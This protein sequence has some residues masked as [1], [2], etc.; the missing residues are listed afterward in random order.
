MNIRVTQAAEG[1]ARRAFTVKEILRMVET[2]ILHPEERF[3]LIKGEIV[4]L[5][6][7]KNEH[8]IVGS[9]LNTILANKAP[10]EV[11]LGIASTLYLDDDTFLEPDVMLYPKRLLPEDVKGSDIIFAVEVADSSFAI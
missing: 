8:E 5:P 9:G 11:R 4:P 6:P 10:D 1:L 3:E 7:K 2:G